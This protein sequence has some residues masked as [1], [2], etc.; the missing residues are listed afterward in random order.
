M[1]RVPAP[2][3]HDAGRATA[4]LAAV[5]SAQITFAIVLRGIPGLLPEVREE[6]DV[7]VAEVG[8]VVF[9]PGIGMLLTMLLWGT[10]AD[11][12][13]E[14]WALPVGM[15]G[16]SAALVL[17]ALADDYWVMIGALVLA[18]AAGGVSTTTSRAAAAW[19]PLE[20]RAR[21]VSLVIT[22]LA[23]GGAIG[24]IGLAVLGEVGGVDLALYVTA[25]AC[26]GSALALA[27]VLRPA[28]DAAAQRAARSG[29]YVPTDARLWAVIVATAL[30]TFA[31]LAT[32]SYIP[33]YLHEE[34]AFGT[35]VAG[36]VL[37]ATMLATAAYRTALAP[38]AD[39]TGDRLWPT[40]ITCAAGAALLAGFAASL[41]GPDWLVVGAAILAPAVM[42]GSN[43]LS[44]TVVAEMVPAEAKGRAL[45]VRNSVV[46]GAGAVAPLA[47]GVLASGIGYG[48]GILMAAAVG[49]A[50]AVLFLVAFRA[51]PE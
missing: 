39:R 46:Y 9:A 22:G 26:A 21:A 45:A 28:P 41:D 40:I 20:R 50:G 19:F 48:A 42:F 24:A 29:R 16:V 30:V 2:D 1:A 43:G 25:G 31:S 51:P 44:A 15:F 49:A 5:L 4:V 27:V 17:A 10:Y 38:V 14:R 34:R 35:I 33:L 23:I 47:F 37:A 3:R 36:F 32:M 12:H 6:F 8:F 11:R 18:G 13:G 7:S